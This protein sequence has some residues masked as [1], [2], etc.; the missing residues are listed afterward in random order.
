VN[1]VSSILSHAQHQNYDDMFSM[2]V[3]Y[4]I[5]CRHGFFAGPSKKLGK[6]AAAKAALAK[7]YNI[8]FSPFTSLLQP[9]RNF[10]SSGAPPV[11]FEQMALPQVLA[12]HIAR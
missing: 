6:A 2:R 9:N 12:D 3:M 4:V 5:S 11:S 8:T 10:G 1:I 7:L